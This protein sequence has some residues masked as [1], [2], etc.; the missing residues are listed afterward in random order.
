MIIYTVRLFK[1]FPFIL[2][3]SFTITMLFVSHCRTAQLGFGA[4]PEDKVSSL[5]VGVISAG[6]GLPVIL[7]MFGGLFVIIK[8][9]TSK[10]GYTDLDTDRSNIQWGDCS[11]FQGTYC[12]WKYSRRIIWCYKYCGL[13]SGFSYFVIQYTHMRLSFVV[14][15]AYKEAFTFHF[16]CMHC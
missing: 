4:P 10:E 12:L 7:I 8:K 14:V 15:E 2:E 3:L 1:S 5:V 13:E 6:L 16:H 11:T 9:K